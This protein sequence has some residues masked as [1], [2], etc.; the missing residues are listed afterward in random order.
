MQQCRV[1]GKTGTCTWTK[2]VRNLTSTDTCHSAVALILRLEFVA[3][4]ALAWNIRLSVCLSV[5]QSV[6]LFDCQALRFLMSA[7][8]SVCICVLC[9]SENVYVYVFDPFP[10]G[11][12]CR[13]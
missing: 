10:K 11:R 2:G 4:T 8:V 9:V 1:R 5:S 6:S 7:S 12:P 3:F 13:P